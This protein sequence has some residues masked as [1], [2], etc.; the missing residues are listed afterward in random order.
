MIL[1]KE[2]QFGSNS[3][4]E[5]EG[6]GAVEKVV[7]NDAP[8]AGEGSLG[9]ATNAMLMNLN[10]IPKAPGS[11]YYVVKLLEEFHSS[12]KLISGIV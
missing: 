12:G 5:T 6:T 9:R 4:K 3:Q 11:H 1:E 2:W 8:W 10:F 7:G